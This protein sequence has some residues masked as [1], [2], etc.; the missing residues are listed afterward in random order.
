[1]VNKSATQIK[2]VIFF[3]QQLLKLVCDVTDCIH[4]S[5]H[6]KTLRKSFPH[7]CGSSLNVCP[8]QKMLF[9]ISSIS[10]S[11]IYHSHNNSSG[12]NQVR[13]CVEQEIAIWLAASFEESRLLFF[14]FFLET[15]TEE[16]PLGCL[17][18]WREHVLIYNRRICRTAQTANWAWKQKSGFFV[19]R[20][21]YLWEQIIWM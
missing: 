2:S 10:S 8:L 11:A 18:D 14:I 21:R 17:L 4:D 19:P 7:S 13:G 16:T 5:R 9:V 12:Q 1:M 3:S 15:P 6:P 20:V